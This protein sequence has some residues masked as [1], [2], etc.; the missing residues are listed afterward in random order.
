MLSKLRR[1]KESK[2]AMVLV[3]II[4][5]PFVFWG[6]GG[7][8]QSGNTNS[9]GKI[10]NHNIS[11]EDFL[12][13]INRS[14]IKE[15]Y[16]KEN[17]DKGILEDLLRDLVS[18]II[19][20][21]EI[22]S[23]GIS[24]SEKTLADKIKKNKIF[25]DE[26]KN[27]SRI[28]YEKFLIEN[29]IT[30]PQYEISLKKNE[31]KNILFN[32]ISKGVN[33]PYFIANQKYIDETKKIKIKY[34]NLNN[35]Y[36]KNFSKKEIEDFINSNKIDLIRDEID[37]SYIKLSP[38]NLTETKEYDTQF[39]KIIDEIENMILNES[40]INEIKNRYKLELVK[41][42]NYYLK[43]SEENALFEEIYEK[44][45]EDKLQLLDKNNF[46]LLYEISNLSEVLPNVDDNNFVNTLNL[47]MI[48]D[49]KNKL[50]SDLFEKITQ[51]QMNDTIFKSLANNSQNIKVTIVEGIKDTTIFDKNSVKLIYSL[52]K[53]SYILITD[54]KNDV[55]LAKILNV[56]FDKLQKNSNVTKQ[57]ILKG[58]NEIKESLYSSYDLY[59][60][61]K[62]KVKLNEK[63]LE[64]VKNYFN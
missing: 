44:R 55:F 37:F 21:L 15:N 2:F 60:N 6:M 62:Y 5:I 45:N 16:I 38:E 50:H 31:Q 57:Y 26:D 9:I 32:Y 12:E 4:I 24:I 33:S 14:G 8:F 36:K 61:T 23:F 3:A 43:E 25:H 20:D 19:L 30:A 59:I 46:F 39:Y 42:K 54:I 63:T 35:S 7:A 64:R 53:E 29:N 27:F 11:T 56:K 1:F 28:K 41:V 47:K 13:H 22:K 17:I 52:P 51:K 58:N 40:K 18:E 48:S 49:N 10:N 34:L